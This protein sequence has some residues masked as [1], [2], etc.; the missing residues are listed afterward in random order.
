MQAIRNI[1]GLSSVNMQT[2]SRAS[3]LPTHEARTHMTIHTVSQCST[4]TRDKRRQ[5]SLEGSKQKMHMHVSYMH[6]RLQTINLIIST[7]WNL[8]VP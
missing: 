3:T 2:I 6:V 1:I 4:A 8:I 5:K 7:N